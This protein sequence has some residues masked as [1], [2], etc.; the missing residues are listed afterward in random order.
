MPEE[1]GKTKSDWS[2]M[3]SG[4]QGQGPLSAAA[5]E[6]PAAFSPDYY[7]ALSA[8][9]AAAR[10]SIVLTQLDT[11]ALL[12]VATANSDDP[13][14]FVHTDAHV[15]RASF[16]AAL[17]AGLARPILYFHGSTTD[18]LR[19]IP[20]HPSMVAV[21]NGHEAIAFWQDLPAGATLVTGEVLGEETHW[22][23][24][25]FLDRLAGGEKCGVYLTS[26]L[27]LAGVTRLPSAIFRRM[28]AEIQAA[29]FGLH[30]KFRRGTYTPLTR[31]TEPMRQ[32]SRANEPAASC[33]YGVWPHRA[34]P[35]SLPDTQPNG[36][37][38]PLISVITPSFNQGKYLGETILSVAGQGY[39]RIEHIVMDGGS[40]DETVSVM[41]HHRHLLA[42]A[43]SEKDRGQS[44]AINKGM[45]LATGDIL[46]WL[47]SDD[48]L[49]PGA[50]A[51]VAMG[52]HTSAADLVAGIVT[53]RVNG[54][55]VGHHMTSCEPG[56]LPLDD[57]LDLDGGWNAGKFFYQPEVMFTR[58]IWERAGGMVREDLYYSMDY[59]LW[60]RM[61]EAGGRLHVIGHPVAWFRMHD[62][63]KTNAEAKFKAELSQYVDSFHARTNRPRRASKAYASPRHQLRI[64]MLNDHGFEY[65]AGIAHQRIAAALKMAGHDVTPFALRA[66]PGYAGEPSDLTAEEVAA[67]IDSISPDLVV[68]GNLHS[69]GPDPWQLGLV[70]E[71]HPTLAV[72]HDFWLLTGR[73]A[74]P[75]PCTKFKTGCDSSCPTAD[76]YPRLDPDKIAG[77]WKRKQSLLFSDNQLIL[78]GNSR[79]TSDFARETM[80]T[81][82]GG[83]QARPV[84][85]F[86]LSFP[87]EVFRTKDRPTCRAILGLPP[88]Q[89]IVLLSGDLYDPRKNTRLALDALASLNLPNLTIVSLGQKRD[90]ERFAFADIRRMGHIN[91]PQRLAN[92]YAAADLYVAPSREETFGQVF[93]ESI[94]CGTPV[95]GVRASGMQ[96][97]VVEG[98]TG[99]LVDEFSTEAL[100][101]AIYEL[102]RKP[103]WR[104]KM[105][106][107]GRIYV[108]N[109]WSTQA[110]YYHMFRAWRSLG[111][112]EK[113]QVPE[114]IG[115]VSEE[116]DL[117][118]VRTIHRSEG[119]TME[120]ASLGPEEGPYPEYS[121]PKFRWAY[122]PVTEMHVHSNTGGAH[123]L[124]LRYRNLH[125]GQTMRLALN[126]NPLGYFELPTTGIA[127]G[128]LVCVKAELKV[129]ANELTMEFTRWTDA[130]K[131][132]R[133][134]AAA[135]TEIR[136]L[137][138]LAA[139]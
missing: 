59:D 28:C 1:T 125:P 103:D 132:G 129:G 123:S 71:R 46:T 95:I 73:C 52:F 120:A 96:E 29:Y 138:D 72:L 122:G 43:V 100:A 80:K 105:G 39:P 107:W 126:G 128:R 15:L 68:T 2:R 3:P 16:R 64:A 14:F 130:A 76:E 79:W 137:P 37:R 36:Q 134:M 34:A 94:A 62:E 118:K 75:T 30:G 110:S 18:F 87:L 27:F 102:Y 121:L 114:K 10:G 57:L 83:R 112:L 98:L 135:I 25:G 113:L 41:Q 24:S 55:S 91:D 111:L 11:L 97:A 78:L 53:L 48:M 82:G 56:P 58:E 81:T 26:K 19:D 89:F 127:K 124:V 23:R 49:A 101:A 32:W 60:V 90:G 31:V 136:F 45:A 38:W 133:Q 51:A 104:R 9:A 139:V 50:L 116:V 12:S 21:P 86:R 131:E 106:Q 115:F 119:L 54:A 7:A 92:L 5:R 67:A 109:E 77:A 117:P 44:N 20:L 88:D 61:A 66:E 70:A 13:V 65:G 40:T 42:A 47:N 69:A 99:L 108:Q 17:R 85:Q 8:A 4:V 35:T 33:G 84:E 22:A 6:C 93:I 63:Q 74:Y